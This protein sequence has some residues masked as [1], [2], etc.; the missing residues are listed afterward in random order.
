M[1]KHL[2]IWHVVHVA[3]SYLL[4]FTAFSTCQN[5][6]SEVYDQK[7][8]GSLGFFTLS[9]LYMTF[10]F[11]SLASGPIVGYLGPRRSMQLGS[12]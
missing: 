6:V 9:V 3:C 2:N 1:E 4:L 11:S 10:A 8:Y 5:V 7:N 12:F